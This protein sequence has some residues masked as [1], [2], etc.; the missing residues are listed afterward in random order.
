MSKI[1]DVNELAPR[2][3]I[4]ILATYFREKSI[5]FDDFCNRTDFKFKKAIYLKQ[6][7]P[8]HNRGATTPLT[9]WIEHFKY[10]RQA[11]KWRA[12]CIITCFPQ[13]ALVVAMLLWFTGR[14]K[15]RL[16]A[17]NFNTS[18]LSSR[19]KGYLAG[20]VLRKV[21]C[22]VV[23]STHEIQSYA[24]WLGID[25]EKFCFIPL[26]NDR[27]PRLEPSPVQKPYI[28]SMGTANRDYRTLIDAVLGTGIKTV[29]IS[30]KRVIDC[31]PD[32]PNLVKLSGLTWEECDNILSCAEMNVVPIASMQTASG[33][34]SFTTSMRMGV[35]TIATRCVGTVDYIQDGETGLLVEPGD[36]QGL[37]QAIER[38][39][40][41]EALRLQIGSA[42]REYAAKYLSA[43]ATGRKLAEVL[44]EVFA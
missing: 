27:I 42:G 33:Q 8:W 17:W 12:D 24:Q 28:V 31:L 14:P 18:A 36:V 2:K 37:R 6:P 43:E 26:P 20:K 5:W 21:D 4:L 38:L 15:P 35:P 7:V 13:L 9:E 22:F 34:V 11:L 32:H 39:W 30:G 3:R 40:H 16:V 10:V 25:K 1:N 44:D 41:D 23:H 19:W 29:V